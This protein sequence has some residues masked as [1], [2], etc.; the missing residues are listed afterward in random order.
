MP[1]RGLHADNGGRSPAVTS[2]ALSVSSME[3][4]R[5]KALFVT[6]VCALALVLA[7][8]A[9][10]CGG[11]SPT[12]D[13]SGSDPDA[14]AYS[15]CMREHGVPNFPDPD[16]E[17][18]IKITSGERN[19]HTFGVDV[20]SPQF[21]KAQKICQKLQP[22]GGA[23][24]KQEQAKEQQSM[25]RFSQCMRSHGVPKYPDPT[26]TSDG[27]IKM[28]MRGTDVN[29]NSPQFAAAKKACKGFLRNGPVDAG[30][31]GK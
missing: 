4:H 7:L 11:G 18:R 13:S 5:Q 16:S 15:A 25:L 22:N 28:S 20:N 3:K 26:F 6:S 23:P 31:P 2:L 19:G 9:S 10:G 27:G 21:K 24:N 12:G 17:G 14:Q 8:V 29:P 30:P 1:H